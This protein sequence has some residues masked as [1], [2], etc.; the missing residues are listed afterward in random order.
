[1]IAPHSERLRRPGSFLDLN[2]TTQKGASTACFIFTQTW[3]R[4]RLSSD[5]AVAYAGIPR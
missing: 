3:A 2:M 5:K 4:I 1:M